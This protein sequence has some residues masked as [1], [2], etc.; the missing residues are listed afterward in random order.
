M[1]RVLV[2]DSPWD[3]PT[4]YLASAMDKIATGA[5][6]I[7][8][9]VVQ[10]RGESAN[11]GT[12]YELLQSFMPD[13]VFL[14]GHGSSNVITMAELEPLLI[15]CQNDEVLAGLQSFFISC[16]CGLV[17]VPS[18]VRKGGVAA[19]GFTEEY[20][21]VITPP[22]VPAE[23]PT[24]R[25]F[26]RLIVEPALEAVRGGGARGWYNKLQA[27]A[28]EEERIWGQSTEAIAAQVL[29]FLRQDKR[30][31]TFTGVGGGEAGGILPLLLLYALTMV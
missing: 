22:Y 24:W 31:A 9:E 10:V 12:L 28:L 14:G 1:V 25:P 26:E 15:A 6:G 21:W 13:Y 8:V 11:I 19:A 27:V 3:L 29:M 2:M 16:L 30:A 20:A 23:D 17:L 4:M 7:G 5:A 18:V